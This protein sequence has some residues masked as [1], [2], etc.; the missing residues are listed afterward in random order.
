[1]SLWQSPVQAN[2]ALLHPVIQ[3]FRLPP[4]W[5]TSISRVAS[6]ASR[7]EEQAWRRHTGFSLLRRRS[8]ALVQHTSHTGLKESQGPN[9]TERGTEECGEPMGIYWALNVSVTLAKD[10]NKKTTCTWSTEGS[11]QGMH[12]PLSKHKGLSP[13]DGKKPVGAF[14]RRKH[15]AS[16]SVCV[17]VHR[18]SRLRHSC[19]L[20]KDLTF[21]VHTT[22]F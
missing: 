5:N 8:D 17:Q 21:K 4:W 22:S 11:D 2:K 3:G 20:R 7:R 13:Q 19:A 1:M 16:P 9:L 6:G 15:F 18:V 10:T 12:R 14:L